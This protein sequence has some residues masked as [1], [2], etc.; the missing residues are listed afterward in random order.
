MAAGTLAYQGGSWSRTEVAQRR[1]HDFIVECMRR[2]GW[3]V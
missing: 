1:L 3:N 2:K